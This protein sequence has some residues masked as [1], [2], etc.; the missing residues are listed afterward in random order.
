MSTHSEAET[1]LPPHAIYKTIGAAIG[2]V[3]ALAV[4]AIALII[5]AVNPQLNGHVIALVSMT[6]IGVIAVVIT[7]ATAILYRLGL[8]SNNDAW[9][10][11]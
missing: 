11:W 3:L 9:V 8:P 4:I 6:G 7:T 1:M 2:T 10:Y 5:A